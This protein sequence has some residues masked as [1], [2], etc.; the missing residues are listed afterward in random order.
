MSELCLF[1]FT[2]CDQLMKDG[3]ADWTCWVELSQVPPFWF[4]GLPRSSEDSLDVPSVG[5]LTVRV[6]PKLA[7][8]GGADEGSH[9]SGSGFGFF[10]S[11]MKL[12]TT[13]C[14]L[15]GT[16]LCQKNDL[17]GTVIGCIKE[18]WFRPVQVLLP[19]AFQ[20]PHHQEFGHQILQLQHSIHRF[21]YECYPLLWAGR[22]LKE[23]W[24]QSVPAWKFS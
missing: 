14:N 22:N 6:A 20:Q 4:V 18:V 24:Y 23:R 2:E 7:I 12:A 10:F 19:Q 21:Y 16:P 9:L 1:S 8:C 17:K 3:Y 15:N 5:G 11:V 13:T